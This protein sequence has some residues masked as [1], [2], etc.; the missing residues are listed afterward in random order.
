LRLH[1]PRNEMN[2]GSLR[3][4]AAR[5][6][7]PRWAP[8]LPPSLFVHLPCIFPFC[9]VILVFWGGVCF[10]CMIFLFF[11]FSRRGVIAEFIFLLP[12]LAFD[13]W[14]LWI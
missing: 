4:A 6:I 9:F 12:S 3:D 1:F 13:F 8:R 11:V 2:C 7:Q 10:S 14:A 5:D